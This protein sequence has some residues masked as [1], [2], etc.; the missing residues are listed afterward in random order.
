M[1]S[2]A[3]AKKC[4][5]VYMYINVYIYICVYIYILC[6]QYKSTIAK[7]EEQGMLGKEIVVVVAGNIH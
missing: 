3:C 5:C 4:I 1:K 2:K 6:L 7:N